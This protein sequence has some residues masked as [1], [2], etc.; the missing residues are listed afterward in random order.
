MGG[1]NEN[2]VLGYEDW[3]FWLSIISLGRQVRRLSHITCF[4][5]Q[6]AGSRSENLENV[7]NNRKLTLRQLVENHSDLYAK[8]MRHK[9][10]V[11]TGRYSALGVIARVVARMVELV[12]GN[13]C[14]SVCWKLRHIV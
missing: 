10:F 1:Y 4:Y 12:A 14:S 3:D 5:R 13:S 2:M 8:H 6:Q 9:N 11:L 7:S